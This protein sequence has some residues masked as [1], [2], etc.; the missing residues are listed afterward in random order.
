MYHA[1]SRDVPRRN[2]RRWEWITCNPASSK[3]LVGNSQMAKFDGSEDYQITFKRGGKIMELITQ[4]EWLVTTKEATHVVIDG[5]QNSIPDIIRGRLDLETDA[6]ER[7]KFLNRRALVVLA[8]VLYSPQHHQF[9]DKLHR[10]NRQVRRVNREASGLASPQPW[11]VLGA[12][13]RAKNE[14]QKDKVIVFP[15]SFSRDGYHISSSKVL[16]YEA[17]L[18]AFMKDIVASTPASTSGN[19]A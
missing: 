14:Q 2:V 3:W 16:E 12:I 10:V 18:A 6:L 1:S 7:L 17:E 8:E 19:Q 9:N 11:R 15:N 4:A 13:Q 5:I